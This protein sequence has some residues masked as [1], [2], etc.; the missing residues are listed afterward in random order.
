MFVYNNASH[1]TSN[2]DEY[3]RLQPGQS[4]SVTLCE[5]GNTGV[6]I[7]TKI[8]QE[9]LHVNGSVRVGNGSEDT[10]ALYLGSKDD[11]FYH[12][13]SGDAG[14]NVIVNNVQEFLFADGG[15]FHAD[16]DITAF[17]TTVDSDIR[18]KENIKP[19]E[20]NLEKV[21]QLKPSSFRWK[22]QD[23]END[24]GLIAQDVEKV[25]PELV[26]EK[27]SIGKTKEFLDGDKH[28]TVDYSKLTTFLI[29][30]VQEQQKQ[31]DEL[32]KKLEEL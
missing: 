20:K 7:G 6:G 22:I 1:N 31:I 21:L 18:L 30:A 9:L 23:R 24:I 25:I 10:P 11:G 15:G 13:T 14:I 3:I 19:L 17:S 5:D 28:K 27:S 12:L 2:T 29:G 26:K 32:K 4:G 16:A 8:P